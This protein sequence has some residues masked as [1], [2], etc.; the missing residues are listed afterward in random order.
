MVAALHPN[1]LRFLNQLHRSRYVVGLAELTQH[2]GMPTPRTLYRW[3][4]SFGDRLIYYPAVAYSAFGLMHW[5]LFIEEP[6]GA[7]EEWPYA[8]RADWV[9]RRPGQRCLY[10]HCLI[11][12]VQDDMIRELLDDIVEMGFAKGV[13]IYTSGDGSQ[14][15][16]G[17]LAHGPDAGRDDAVAWR[18][19][20][21]HDVVERYPLVIPV[22]FEM[23]EQRRSMPLLWNVIRERL[24]EQVWEYLPPR[25]HRLGRNGKVYVRQALRVLNDAFLI[26]EH[27]IRFQPLEEISVE[28]IALTIGGPDD[29]LNLVGNEPPL[30]DVFPTEHETTVIRVCATLP[31]LTRFFSAGTANIINCF[32]VDHTMNEREPLS[33]RFR[34]EDLFDPNTSQWIFAREMIIARL[35]R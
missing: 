25:I 7:W 14:Y 32:F 26:R 30:V 9:V 35:S 3:H 12:R 2:N 1:V 19:A 15:L 29:A 6:R 5:H 18:D 27:V 31:F 17:M 33:V 16:R 34:Y 13:T 28:L 8:I 24:G 21:V 20:S 4:R 22:T 23:T 10:L 11:P